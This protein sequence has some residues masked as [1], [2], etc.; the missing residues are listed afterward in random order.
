[1]ISIHS[2]LFR[3]L[4]TC[5]LIIGAEA[6]YSQATLNGNVSDAEGPLIGATIKIVGTLTGTTTD[7]D[8]NYSMDLDPGAY[9]LEA[10]Y[11]GYTALQQTITV[12]QGRNALDFMMSEGVLLGDIVVTGTRSNPRTTL[13]SPVPIDNFVSEVIDKQGNGDLTENL[14]NIV[15]SF[16]AT[17]LTGDGA[18]F[19]RPTSL[20]GLPPDETLVLVNSKRRHRSSL[21]AH[22]GAAMNVGAHAVDIGHIP[23]IAIKNLEVLRDGAAAQYGSDAIAGVFNFLLKDS[24]EGAEVQAQVGQW[25]GR[26]YG[27]ETDYKV[28]ANFGLPLTEKG[29]INLSAEYAFNEELKRGNQHAAA[30]G[31]AGAPDPV[32]NW[33]RPESS[34][35]K[36]YWNAGIEIAPNVQVYSHG[37]YSDTYGNYSFFFRAPGHSSLQA[38]PNDPQDPSK[39]NYSWGDIFPLG[40]TPRLEGFQKDFSSVLGVKVNLEKA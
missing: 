17:P 12:N 24:N 6:I 32:M 16:S 8:G 34:G 29:F 30:I 2:G 19:V 33:G 37:N 35:F 27:A 11:T 15:P 14:K 26:N 36:S 7:L 25:Y 1:M 31:L 21:I 23:S 5:I 22:F 28:A 3:L 4:M 9:V 40:Y 18:A 39:G 10:T 13:S 20:R 38:V